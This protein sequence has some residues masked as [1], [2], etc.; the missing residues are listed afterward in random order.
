MDPYDALDE[1]PA[2]PKED[3]IKKAFED[4]GAFVSNTWGNMKRGVAKIFHKKRRV[5]PIPSKL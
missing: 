1:P 3:K 5:E 2:P 4:L